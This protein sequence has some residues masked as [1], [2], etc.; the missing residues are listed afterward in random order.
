MHARIL[1]LLG[2]RDNRL[3]TKEQLFLCGART[4]QS[5]QAN[6]TFHCKVFCFLRNRFLAVRALFE[7]LSRSFG[8]L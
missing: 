7:R 2:N 6:F 3:A 4:I 1:V 5:V 8:P